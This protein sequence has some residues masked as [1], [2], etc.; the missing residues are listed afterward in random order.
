[1]RHF[2]EERRAY[3]FHFL[4]KHKFPKA[5]T[6][7]TLYE[8][9]AVP[10]SHIISTCESYP[11]YPWVIPQYLWG[12]AVPVS[13]IGQLW[14]SFENKASQACYKNTRIIKK[15]SLLAVH[16]RQRQSKG[17]IT[18]HSL[19]K[20]PKYLLSLNSYSTLK[21]SWFMFCQNLIEILY[22]PVVIY[23]S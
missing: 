19:A 3:G 13:H 10:M 14:T 16:L 21:S 1:M 2:E 7:F 4:H 6:P 18:K 5:I 17:Q 23:I 8:L 11:Q 15:L 12:Y 22:V 20:F 9:Y